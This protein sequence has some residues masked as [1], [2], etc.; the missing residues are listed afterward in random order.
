LFEI[1]VP[2]MVGEVIDSSKNKDVDLKQR[3][4]ITAINGKEIKYFDEFTPFLSTLKGQT[5]TATILRDDET[6]TREL[7]VDNNGKLN[8]HPA[9]DPR[10]FSELGYFDIVKK[11]YSFA[12]SFGVGYNRFTGQISSYFEQLKLIFSPST[13]AY[14]GVGGFKAIFDI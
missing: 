4:I 2:F 14:K 12:E 3:D 9:S 6:L 13:G 11:E 7:Y 10:R 5:V 1:R 8:I